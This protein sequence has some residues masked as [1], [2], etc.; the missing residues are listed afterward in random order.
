M[1]DVLQTWSDFKIALMKCEQPN[2]EI[3]PYLHLFTDVNNV[4]AYLKT[5]S[6]YMNSRHGSVPH[7]VDLDNEK[8]WNEMKGP[9]YDGFK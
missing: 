8:Y 1:K 7:N 2:F 9:G 5:K 3:G 6:P 4:L